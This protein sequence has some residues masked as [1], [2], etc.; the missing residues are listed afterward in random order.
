MAFQPLPVSSDSPVDVPPAAASFSTVSIPPLRV[1]LM[2]AR[3]TRTHHEF[4]AT[5]VALVSMFSLFEYASMKDMSVRLA[6]FVA[7]VRTTFQS[8]RLMNSLQA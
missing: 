4:D 6:T 3:N 1:D 5:V 2:L 8:T 7:Q